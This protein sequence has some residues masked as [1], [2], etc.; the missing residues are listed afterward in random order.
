VLTVA[1]CPPGRDEVTVAVRPEAIVIEAGSLANAPNSVAGVVEQVVYRGF[2]SHIY[3][4]MANDETL[5]VFQ[6]NGPPP[7]GPGNPVV[8]RW[9]AK[10][11]R[12]VHDEETAT[13]CAQAKSLP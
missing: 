1:D 10:S 4:R 3:V 11:N 6:S 8:A 12:V 5:I 13:A 9:D 7:P 2:I